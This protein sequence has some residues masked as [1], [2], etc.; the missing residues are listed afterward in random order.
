MMQD[1]TWDTVKDSF[2]AIQDF[3]DVCYHSYFSFMD[4]LRQP[5][6]GK[7]YEIRYAVFLVNAWKLELFLCVDSFSAIRTEVQYLFRC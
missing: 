2:T 7:Y 6:E 5:Q 4:D 3:K 1:G